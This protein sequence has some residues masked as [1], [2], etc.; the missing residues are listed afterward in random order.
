MLDKSTNSAFAF[1]WNQQLNRTV[2]IRHQ[3]SKTNVLS[4]HRCL[5]GLHHLLVGVTDPEYKLLCCIQLK[6]I[7]QREESTSF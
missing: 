3:C 4:C 1:S 2:H 5:I 6:N 7:L